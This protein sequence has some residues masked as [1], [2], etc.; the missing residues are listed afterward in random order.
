MDIEKLAQLLYKSIERSLD[1]NSAIAFSGGLDSS[2]LATVAKKV[3]KV[4]LITVSTEESTQDLEAAR[5]VACEL[6]LA[7]HE[8]ILTPKILEED[9]WL[10][11]DMMQ[12]SMTELELMCGTLECAKKAHEL[13]CS[14]MLMG[15]GSEELFVG[16]SKYYIALKHGL[17]L[18]AILS[19][20]LSTLAQ[21]DIARIKKVCEKYRIKAKFPF[22]DEEFAEAIK[23]IPLS[24]KLDD[25]DMKKP[26]LRKIAAALGVPKTA[27]FR[28]KK[29]MQYGSG[30]HK[31]ME[32]LMKEG[33]IPR[34]KSRVWEWMKN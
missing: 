24:E 8:V 18:Q 28:P 32:K 11:W 2:T 23:E 33:R 10:C 20:E 31:M 29:A 17:D 9:F 12:G 3:A 22:L 16:Y 21:R 4:Q 25:G 1:Q 27:I 15:T 14:T 13:G 26:L 30:I 6:G 5:A 19:K 7:L 34:L